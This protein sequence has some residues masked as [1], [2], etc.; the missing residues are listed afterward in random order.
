M[1]L[2][3]VSTDGIKDATIATADLANDAVTT[4]KIANSAI[5]NDK[6]NNNS[7]T[8]AKI[9]D[10]QITTSKINADAVTQAK[11]AANAIGTTQIA[12]DAVT[13]AKVSVPLTNRNLIINGAMN[14]AQRGTTSTSTSYQTID[15][16]ALL[17]AGVEEAPTQHQVDVGSN[18]DPYYEGFRKAFKITNGNQTSGDAPDHIL[19]RYKVEAQDIANSGW[20]Y[21]S[22]TSY[23]TLSY[24][25]RSSVEQNFYFNLIAGD[26]TQQNYAYETGSLSANT[27]TKITKTISGNSNL[28]FNNDSG[29]G[30]QIDW[31]AYA[32]T[33]VTNSNVNLNQ[34]FAYSSTNR[35]PNHTSTWFTTNDSTLEITGVQLEVGSEATNFE[36]RSYQDDVTRCMRYFQK[37]HGMQLVGA[38]NTASRMRMNAT[39][40]VPMRAT[41]TYARTSHGFYFQ[42]SGTGTESTD[43]TEAQGAGTSVIDGLS[44]GRQWDFGGFSNLADRSYIGSSNQVLFEMD[45]EL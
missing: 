30:L 17:T 12:D 1:A 20:N 21:Q 15:R 25:I 4:A 42:L 3:K 7:I 2:S 18:K 44:Y 35:M 6:L 39:F 40:M 9:N 33:S 5:T 8:T 29:V 31:W 26:G 36:H 19:I 28:T 34:W 38:R 23:V 14:V 32:G 43:T 41:P 27:W 16:F 24:W 22:A 10:S 45:S 11:I 37:V 13:K